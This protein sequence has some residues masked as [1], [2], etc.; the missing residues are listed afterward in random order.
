M[1][2]HKKN[3]FHYKIYISNKKRKKS[4]KHFDMKYVIDF[5]AKFG[6]SKKGRGNDMLP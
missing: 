3:N 5:F 6:N 2:R 1:T 4:Q